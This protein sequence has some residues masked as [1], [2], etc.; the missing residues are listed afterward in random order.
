MRKVNELMPKDLKDVCN[1]SLFKFE[2]TKELVDTSDL[3][4]GQERGIK[5][6]EFGTDIDIKGY[7]LYLEGPSGVGKTMYT[8]KFLDKKAEKGKVPNDWVYIY[9]FENPNEPVAVSFPAGQGKIF[10]STMENFIKDVRR[11]IKKTFNN[12]DFEKEKQ[13]I[14]QEFEEKRENL[15]NKLNQKTMIQGFQVKSTSNGVYMMPV[16]DGRTLAEDEFEELD[17]SI[18]KEF[19]ERSALVQEQIFQALGEIKA[20]EREAEKKVDEWQSNIALMTIN[21]HVNS[22]KAN[23]KRNK[24]IGTYL[25]NIKK[26]ILKNINAFLAPDSD[27]KS[28]NMP[29]QPMQRPEQK[30]PWLNYRVNLFIDNSKLEGAPVIMDTNYSYYNIFGGLEYENQYG[31]LKT[32]YMMIKPGLLHQANGGYIIFQAKDILANGVCYEALKKALKIRELS[33][34]NATEQRAGVLLAAIKPE[35]IPLNIKVL[36]VGNSNI[37]HTLLS[38]DDDFR[39][40]FKIKVEFE[41]DAPKTVEN[42]ERLSNFVRSFCTQEKLLDLDKEAMAKVVEITSNLAGDKERLST[43]F[44]E[45]G[46]VIG[47]ASAWAK[48]DRQKIITKAYIQKALDERIERIKKYDT[49]YLQMIKEES[50]LIDTEGYEVGQINGLTVIKI[51]DYSFGKPA[52]IT[53]S[54]YMGKEGIINIEREIEMSGSSHSKGVLILTGY[55]G[56]KFAQDIPL[57]LTANLCFEQL[58]GGVDGDSASSTEAYAL[59]SSLSGVPINQ[60][61]AVTGSVNQKGYIQPIGGVNEK[62]EGFFQ[63]CKLRGFNGEQG[64]I[65][66]KQNIRNLHLSDEIIEA[67]K[68]K[69]F[70]IY[71]ITTIDEGIEI[72]TG[73]PAGKRNKEGKFPAGSINYLAQEKLKKFAKIN[74][75]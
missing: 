32:D 21:V 26:D 31:S 41:E 49:R 52:R 53:A 56:E 2:T 63:I 46:E 45:I 10:A 50:L 33:I 27:S 62:I 51:G 67:V 17:D 44:S 68:D 16:L 11:D 54:T 6:L 24:K 12:D 1:P 13:I 4:Y 23:Y 60:S 9:N 3:V 28:N 55:L 30:E 71:A 57:S 64:V 40:L 73:V 35:P 36:L 22:I 47:E 8:K 70:H 25:D 37:Y 29:N 15:L 74:E 34:E 58:Y 18:K 59:L 48:K 20:I 66:P 38:M 7:N 75:K 39:K 43:Q 5:A 61:I 14:K 19:E 72:L 42:I 65:I 69:K